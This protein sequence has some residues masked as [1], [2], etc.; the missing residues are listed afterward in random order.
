MAK[1]F[2]NREKY[3]LRDIK[4]S[5]FCLVFGALLLAAFLWLVLSD[6]KFVWIIPLPLALVIISARSII[7]SVRLL[8]Q[9]SN[10]KLGRFKD[11]NVSDPK[12]AFLHN[13]EYNRSSINR[14]YSCYGV[15]IIGK[16]KYYYLFGEIYRFTD[17]DIKKIKDKLSGEV[18]IQCYEGTTII[19]TIENDP[20]FLKIKVGYYS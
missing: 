14:S 4:I 1:G 5:I 9:F 16:Q 12:I 19:K 18:N 11:I 20:H 3:I 15:K 17:E 10:I 8:K 13:P 6:V 2:E 7:S